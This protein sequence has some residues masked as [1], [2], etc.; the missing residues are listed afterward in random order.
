M[1]SVA[2]VT[3]A[4]DHDATDY[5]RAQQTANPFASITAFWENQALSQANEDQPCVSTAC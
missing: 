1:V 3:V 2:A 4:V 5:H